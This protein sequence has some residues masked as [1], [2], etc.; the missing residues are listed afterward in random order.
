MKYA[1][2]GAHAVQYPVRRLCSTLAVH[3]SGY[4]AWKQRPV[5]ARSVEDL[6]VGALITQCWE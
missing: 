6:R 5:S 2:I 1:F 4:Y 3:P